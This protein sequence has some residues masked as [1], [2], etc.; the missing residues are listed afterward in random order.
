MSFLA[1]TFAALNMVSYLGP[2]VGK[3]ML[4]YWILKKKQQCNIYGASLVAQLVKNLP[5]MWETWVWPLGWEDPLEKGMATHSMEYWPSIPWTVY[6]SMGSQR[7][8]HKWVTS[9]FTF[10]IRMEFRKMVMM[11]LYARQQERHKCKE[12][13]FGYERIA[14]KHVY[15]HM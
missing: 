11:T 10:S 5:A 9:T 12:Q 13:T 8:G 14:L 7:V 2:F 6:Q 1:F 4:R 3:E 15:Y